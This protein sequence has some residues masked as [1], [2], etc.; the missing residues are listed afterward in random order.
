VGE[1]QERDGGV[2]SRRSFCYALSCWALSV[3]AAV[4]SVTYSNLNQLPKS[5][6]NFQSGP[7]NGPVAVVFV[8][9]FATVG[10]LLAWKRPAN[11][12]GWLPS[13]AALSFSCGG[14]SLL[15]AYEPGTLTLA[16]WLGWIWLFGLGLIVPVLLIFPTGRLLSRRW[17]P[18][19]WAAPAG[20]A[21]WVLGN[22]LAPTS[23]SRIRLAFPAPPGRPS[24]CWPSPGP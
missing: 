11:A 10:A 21:A 9:A 20:L 22:A 4:I 2:P 17:R 23:G 15:F 13:A 16:N 6:S 1:R 24:S 7:A 12:I 3:S 8:G 19:A 14:V 5:A 18:V